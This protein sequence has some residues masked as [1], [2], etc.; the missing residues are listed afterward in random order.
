MNSKTLWRLCA[1]CIAFVL[2][3]T[4]TGLAQVARLSDLDSLRY[5]ASHGDLIEAFGADASKG[6]SH[7]EQYGVKEG[8]TITFD[9]NRY[10]ASHAD[11]IQAFKGD[12]L[13]ATTHYIQYGYKE[14]RQTTF[15]DL[16]A[17]QYIASYGDLIQAFGTNVI[18]AIRHYVSLGY[19]E[20]RRAI[21]DAL[22]YIASHGDL[23]AAF[24]TN[25]LAGAKH[26]IESGYKEGRQVVF[27]ALG[28]LSRH[29]DLQQAFGS[30]AVAATKHYINWGFKEG[31]QY[32]FTVS[33]DIS[34][35]GSS[36]LTKAFARAG[37]IVSFTLVPDAGHYL[38]AVTGCNG[39]LRA[40]VYT[41]D[42][43][44]RGCKVIAE[45]R[46]DQRVVV[47][48]VVYERLDSQAYPTDF[49]P[50]L[51]LSNASVALRSQ[52][53]LT[54]PSGG[55][56][57]KI[58]PNSKA[59]ADD[60]KVSSNG[61]ITGSWPWLDKDKETTQ[62]LGLYRTANVIRRPEFITG[63]VPHDVGGVYVETYRD[64]LFPTTMQRG[65]DFAGA[66]LVTLVDTIE[67]TEIDVPT[68]KVKMV[69]APPWPNKFN[70]NISAREIYTDLASNARQRNM[71]L[72]MMIQI[73]PD[74]PIIDSY[75]K[76]L[77]LLSK[78]STEFF[79]SWFSAMKPLVVERAV[80]A[81]DLRMEYLVVGLNHYFLNSFASY[82]NWEG[83]VSAI[84]STGYA[85]K[86]GVF[87]GSF[88]DRQ[89]SYDRAD[90]VKFNSLFD[91]L[92][93][94]FYDVVKPAFDGEILSR[95]QPRQ[96]MRDDIRKVLDRHKE[97]AKPLMVLMGTPSVFGGVSVPEY[98]EP[99]LLCTSL[100]PVRIKDVQQQA[101]AYQAMFEVI[102]ERPTGAGE[103]MGVLTWG[104]HYRDDPTRLVSFEDPNIQA[105][106]KSGSVR[107]KPAEA[108]MKHWSFEF[109]K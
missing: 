42:P 29:T 90:M 36:S 4:P 50:A 11:L 100:A 39:S 51:G 10:M 55:F 2:S 8:R 18:S 103:V 17:L 43:I 48:G 56:E 57:L 7:Y 99:C 80:I 94:S 27:D 13:K 97:F 77:P 14:R 33:V 72:M 101:D 98:I 35:A 6:R 23:I 83:L 75:F 40:N 28:Y 79:D 53:V 24:G 108:I 78:S 62:K 61:H 22:A 5:I 20:G 73:Y 67:V 30:D 15:S 54:Q 85:G 95:A 81:R 19:Q 1:V 41:T 70:P 46:V 76:S 68:A 107:G 65:K 16:D 63:I 87:G 26:Y 52:S 25:A 60:L 38:H 86:I 88:D 104:Y 32:S 105:Y 64:G 9:P 3:I 21:F 109:G 89:Y 93:L 66:N 37:E 91:F 106:D 49:S 31:R 71:N 82:R 47:R 12:E 96:R 69:G 44:L 102:N 59:D 34:G 74:V 45:F 58:E 92:G 84:R